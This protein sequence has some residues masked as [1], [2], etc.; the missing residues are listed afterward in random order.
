MLIVG[1][2]V[3][4][5]QTPDRGER[6]GRLGAR[7]DRRGRGEGEERDRRGAGEASATTFRCN[8]KL[9]IGIEAE[10]LGRHRMIGH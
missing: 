3:Q 1:V 8:W 10:M 4:G 5:G 7:Q 2:E 6:A 9:E